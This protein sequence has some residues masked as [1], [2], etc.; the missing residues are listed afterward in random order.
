MI[1]QLNNMTQLIAPQAISILNN[2]VYFNDGIFYD[3]YKNVLK[4]TWVVFCFWSNENSKFGC[5]IADKRTENFC[6]QYNIENKKY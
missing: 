1:N 4:N 5:D 3:K 6:K 2:G